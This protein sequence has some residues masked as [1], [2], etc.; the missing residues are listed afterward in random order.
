MSLGFVWAGF[1][2]ARG[3]GLFG[4]DRRQLQESGNASEL[5][6]VGRDSGK[7]SLFLLTGSVQCWW[8][9]VWKRLGFGWRLARVF[10]QGLGVEG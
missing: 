2:L 4:Q 5:W 7:R 9:P 8:M 6:D 10:D 1:D 3:Q